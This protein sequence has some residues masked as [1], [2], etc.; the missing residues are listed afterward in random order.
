VDSLGYKPTNNYTTYY[1]QNGNPI[2]W[3]ITASQPYSLEAYEWNFPLVGRVNYKGYFN[4]ELANKEYLHLLAEGYDVELGSV[5]AWSTLGWFSDPVLSN[6]LKRSKGSLCNL[7]FHELFH[8]TY[9]APNSVDFN[10]NIASFIAHKAT[11]RYLK[12][13]SMALNDYLQNYEDNKTFSNYMLRSI[14]YLNNYYLKIKDNP[15]RSLL[16]LKAL[17][18]IADS[19][20]YL[21]LHEKERF[22]SRKKEILKSK[23]AYFVDFVQYDSMQDSFENIFNKIYRGNIEKMAQDL[24]VN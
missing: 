1:N 7:L 10:E 9:Y 6:M 8:T 5:S 17:M 18:Q 19:I 3:V 16:K 11:I 2:L 4:K 12:T 20:A 14:T 13:D 21:P 24:K 15:Q 23:N 22:L